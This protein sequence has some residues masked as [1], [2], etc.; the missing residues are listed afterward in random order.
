MRL[1]LCTQVYTHRSIRLVDKKSNGACIYA[2][3]R[4]KKSP[5][6]ANVR[7]ANA[8]KES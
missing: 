4:Y 2:G 8:K 7:G 5:P 1:G 3:V 6:E